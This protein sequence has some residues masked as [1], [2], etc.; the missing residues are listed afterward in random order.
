MRRAVP[1]LVTAALVLVVLYLAFRLIVTQ[2][3]AYVV[4][5]VIT[6]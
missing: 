1:A 3:V 4:E 6:G 5:K 2:V